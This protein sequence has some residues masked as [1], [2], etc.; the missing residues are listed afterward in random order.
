MSICLCASSLYNICHVSLRHGPELEERTPDPD[1]YLPAHI[2]TI[3]LFYYLS[4]N[5]WNAAVEDLASTPLIKVL[6][7]FQSL[8]NNKISINT[9]ILVN[10]NLL[11]PAKLKFQA[12]LK[13]V[14]LKLSSLLIY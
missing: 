1:H 14:Y 6:L 2:T 3:Y 13:K 12:Y 11:I 5:L 8:F 4:L 10:T 7:T 9:K